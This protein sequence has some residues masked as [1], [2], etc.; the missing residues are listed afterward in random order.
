MALVQ[1]QKPGPVNGPSGPKK[2]ARSDSGMGSKN[3]K[4]PGTGHGTESMSSMNAPKK[5]N[6]TSKA[7]PSI[8]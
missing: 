5:T 6:R 3:V 2:E 4:G 7:T 8:P 1:R